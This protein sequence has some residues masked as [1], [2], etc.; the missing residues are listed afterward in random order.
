ME[1]QS[2]CSSYYALAERPLTHMT[3]WVEPTLQGRE[4][5]PSSA[6]L[7]L[8]PNHSDSQEKAQKGV[9]NQANSAWLAAPYSI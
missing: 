7:I 6:S 1:L 4:A 9:A 3:R 5:L 8:L 2:P